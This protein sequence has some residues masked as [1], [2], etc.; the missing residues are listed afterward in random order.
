MHPLT[1]NFNWLV[2][3]WS[4]RMTILTLSEIYIRS[5]LVSRPMWLLSS[6]RSYFRMWG[7]ILSPRWCFV[8][9]DPKSFSVLE[10]EKVFR[11]SA[12]SELRESAVKFVRYKL[13]NVVSSSVFWSKKVVCG[14]CL[15]F[16]AIW[17]DLC[18]S[19]RLSGCPFMSCHSVRIK[20]ASYDV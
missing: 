15:L 7:H 10:P 20:K 16:A 12:G 19:W 8:C 5:S 17:Q 14:S 1:L 4:F 3:R 11:F 6:N 13:S 2:N 9:N 18:H